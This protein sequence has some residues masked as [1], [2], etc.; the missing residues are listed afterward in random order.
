MEN[1]SA[2][3]ASEKEIVIAEFTINVAR[4]CFV[5]NTIYCL[6]ARFLVPVE[7]SK[8]LLV[9]SRCAVLFSLV[10][11]VASEVSQITLPPRP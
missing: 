8:M 5:C 9:K 4:P 7:A 6:C 1:I 3:I 10:R 2:Y 11:N